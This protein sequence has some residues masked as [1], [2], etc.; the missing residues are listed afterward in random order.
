MEKEPDVLRIVKEDILEVLG[1]EK[2]KVLLKSMNLEVKVS[3]FFVSKAIKELEKEN[4]IKTLLKKKKEI[5][6]I[7]KRGRR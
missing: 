2:N 5:C 7:N 6:S 4:L 1:R 3:S